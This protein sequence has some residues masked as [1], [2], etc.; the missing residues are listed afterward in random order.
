M[1]AG[2]PGPGTADRRGEPGPAAIP[3]DG[4]P[5]RKANRP[6]RLPAPAG[7]PPGAV[8]PEAAARREPHRG[9]EPAPPRRPSVVRWA[10]R[11]GTP[12]RGG[13]RPDLQADAATEKGRVRGA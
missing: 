5:E 4:S 11:P 13:Q 2:R 10:D 9:S 7:R 8:R 3:A 1:G 6:G 12:G